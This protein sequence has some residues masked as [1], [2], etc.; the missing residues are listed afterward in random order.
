L[1]IAE[2]QS[3]A[4]LGL[5][6]FMAVGLYAYIYHLYTARKDADGVDYEEYANLALND[7][8]DDAPVS[9]VSKEK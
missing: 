1:G 2:L 5:T 9:S 6:I 8:I 7:D 4:Y 3:Y